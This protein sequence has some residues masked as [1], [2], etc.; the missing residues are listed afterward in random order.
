MKEKAALTLTNDL[1]QI[2]RQL[3]RL[4]FREPVIAGLTTSEK[5][6]LLLLA[7]NM[8]DKKVAPNASE[9]SNLMQITP[10]GVTHLL[11][12]LEEQGCIERLPDPK[13]R[14]IVRIGI[15]DRG[16]Q[17]ARRVA[18]EAQRQVMGLVR[19]LG[20]EDSRNLIRLMS[21]AIEYFTAQTG[22]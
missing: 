20:E 13:D 18:S 22:D 2:I 7:I 17:A 11:N 9:I 19:H 14:R 6:L 8:D 10:A 12:A 3:P 15:T 4:K 21:T 5:G 16:N 1:L